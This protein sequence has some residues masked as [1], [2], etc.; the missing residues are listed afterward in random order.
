MET[1]CPT[2]GTTN[3]DDATVC[4]CGAVLTHHDESDLQSYIS[5]K[6][7][8]FALWL[9]IFAGV[10]A[11]ILI[12]R[13][14]HGPAGQQD[15]VSATGKGKTGEWQTRE[16]SDARISLV[17][18]GPFDS[19]S[20]EALHLPKEVRDTIARA[21]FYRSSGPG[22]DVFAGRMQSKKPGTIPPSPT[23][24]RP[25]GDPNGKF[26]IETRFCVAGKGSG[27]FMKV[28]FS[29]NGQAIEGTSI[30]VTAPPELWFITIR[31]LESDKSAEESAQRIIDS[32]RIDGQPLV[33]L[34]SASQSLTGSWRLSVL[35]PGEL[36][37]SAPMPWTEMESAALAPDSQLPCRPAGARYFLC[38]CA[39]TN[40]VVA[41][42]TCDEDQSD[43][44]KN[45]LLVPPPAGASP[46]IGIL[47]G[48][49]A[50]AWTTE[51]EI[52]GQKRIRRKVIAAE[53]SQSWIFVAEYP[54]GDPSAK[55]LV[56]RV[57]ASLEEAR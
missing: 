6:I 25:D 34:E 2:C 5:T 41:T 33:I 26:R 22:F 11:F 44:V 50:V 15:P 45:A 57:Q 9:S 47:L 49:R 8:N 37:A 48:L 12:L 13:A 46:Q 51:S 20:M 16:L 42:G 35:V 56:E 18:P 14:L 31:H 54:S 23:F 53:G 38:Q 29:A 30:V 10:L 3:P 40:F 28:H 24:G 21:D 36:A 19:V 1:R 32:I 52:G 27:P 4:P 55:A 7:R 39:S 17:A 43:F